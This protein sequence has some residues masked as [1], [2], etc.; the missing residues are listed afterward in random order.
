M[1]FENL[2]ELT[3][4]EP[5]FETGLLLSGCVDPLNIRKQLSRWTTSGKIIQ[6]RRGLY[7]L[8][9]PYQKITP[10]PFLIANQLIKASYISL[11]SALAYYGLIPEYVPVFTSVTTAHPT[12]FSNHFGNFE[13]RHIQK[14]WFHSYHYLNFGDKQ[15]AFIAKPE[16]ALLDLIY[17]QPGGDDL[18]YLRGLRLQNLDQLNPAF[19]T[20][21]AFESEKPKLKQAVEHILEI[22]Q[23]EQSRFEEL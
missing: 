15:S 19:L 7:C 8:A 12:T 22:I 16:K 13:F 11:Q 20:Q 18:D 1:N 5:L 9:S 21:L 23:D 4:N 3:Q 2:L 6:L 10:H 14:N 17:L